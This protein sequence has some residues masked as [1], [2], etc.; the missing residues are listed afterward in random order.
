MQ[1]LRHEV[2]LSWSAIRGYPL[3]AVLFTLLFLAVLVMGVLVGGLQ[4]FAVVAVVAAL[5]SWAVLRLRVA[6]GRH[7]ASR[8]GRRRAALITVAAVGVLTL[9]LAQLVPFGRAHSNP[10]VTGEPE[11]ATPETREL[12]EQACFQCHSNLVEYPW[13]SDIAP[14][15]WAVQSHINGGRSE[16]NYSEFATDPGNADETIEVLQDGSMPPAYF[17]RFGRNPE[18]ILSDAELKQLIAG[19]Q[20][21][22]GLAGEDKSEYGADED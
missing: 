18:A 8:A 7:G 16:V 12:M 3:L 5:G 19:L 13:Y 22:P 11:W 14:M 21:T 9:A 1:R 15:S 17:T 10:P 4:Q 2:S 6:R 20:A